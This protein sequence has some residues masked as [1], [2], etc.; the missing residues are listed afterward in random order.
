MAEHVAD[1]SPR[2]RARTAGCLYSIVIV[3]G[4][5]SYGFVRSSIIFPGDAAATA[6]NILTHKF[7]FRL[8]FAATIVL[9]S[10]NVPLALLFFELFKVVK[11]SLALLVAFLIMV[12]TA[13]EA[14]TLLFYFAPLMLLD[15]GPQSSSFQP[16]Q[17]QSL[18]YMSLQL[19]AIGFNVAAVFFGSYDLVIAYLLIRASFLPRILGLL[20][21]IGGS[22]YLIDS[23][24]TFL[25]PGVAARLLPLILV[26]S[27]AAE[28]ALCLWLILMGVN[29]QRW[30]EQAS[31]AHEFQSIAAL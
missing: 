15:G 29:V 27:G 18:A 21:A 11:R 26:P 24:V 20:M 10:C 16:E 17:L 13:V 23:F 7:L 19:Q 4:A 14:V 8:G 9:L 2:V 6:H 1:T 25:F 28:L 22:C 30:Y 5:F 31:I 3:A 12:G